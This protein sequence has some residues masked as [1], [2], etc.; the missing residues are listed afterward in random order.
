MKNSLLPRSFVFRAR[1]VLS[2]II[3]PAVFGLLLAHAQAG[4]TTWSGGG[5]SNV[6]GDANNWGGT[7]V[8]TNY[9]TVIFN[10][11]GAQ[12]TTSVINGNLSEN[13]LRWTGGSSWTLNNS[14]G[15][16]LSLYDNGGTQ[17]K[18]ENQSTGLV[19]INAP[20]IFAANN[21][22]PP[23]PFGEINAVNGD[24]TFASGTLTVNGSSVN[25]VKLFGSNHTTTFNNTVSS[26]G[27]WIGLT[28]ATTTMAVGGAF[29]SGD[30]YAMNGGTV[31]LNSGGTIT[32]SALRLGGDFG[33]TGNQNQ[34]LGGTFQFTNLTGGQ[35]FSGIINTVSGNTSNALLI[36]SL[37]TSGTNTLAGASFLDSDLKTQVASG[38]TLN[39]AGG[40][41]DVKTRKLT[42][43]GAGTTVINEALTSS[44]GAGGFLVK[45]GTGTL[46]LQGTANTYTGTSNAT[47]NAN[48]TQIA[49]GT[50]GIHGDGSLGLAPAGAYNNIQFT[51]SGTLQDTANNISLN[52]NR[53]V[54]ITSGATATFDSNGNTF[55]INGAIGGS[56]GNVGKTGGGSVVLN[57][58]NSYT[59][60]TAI[61][62]GTLQVNANNGLG[63]NAAGT[64]VSSGAALKLNS[65]NYSTVE[66]LQINGTGVS[67]GGALVNS[68]TS[69][70]AGQITA[71]TSSLISAGGGTLTLTGGI[72]KNGTTV[73][74]YGGPSGGAFNIN[75][76]GISGASANSDLVVDNASVALNVASTYNGPT[77]IRNA[78]TLNANV[79]NALPTLRSAMILDD[80]GSGS[81]TLA[82]GT[83]TN[84]VIASLTGAA[85]SV[86]ALTTSSSLTIGTGSGVTTFAGTIVG[87]PGTPIIKDSASTQ[88]LTGN[89][90]T[91]QGQI[92]VTAGVLE[93]NNTTGSASGTAGVS[94]TAGA[95]L[96]GTGR[97]E[98][99][100]SGGGVYINGDLVVGSTIGAPSVADFEI[101]T[102]AFT[103]GTTLDV[104]SRLTMELFTGA[105]LGDNS[106]LSTAAD[107]LK[108]VGKLDISN[109]ARL[110]V[111]NPN[112]MS[113]WAVGDRWR[114]FDWSSVGTITGSFASVDIALPTLS[115]G[116]V[117]DTSDLLTT[118]G[119]FSGTIDILAV[120]EPGSL[121]VGIFCGLSVAM[122][123]RRRQA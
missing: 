12:G 14:G 78:G 42:V 96:A 54:S 115:A 28:G 47:L 72:V 16:V 123:R 68:G 66:A 82:I 52:A 24:V 23:N 19:T 39:F 45:E 8:F 116:L 60:T 102:N 62:Q 59:G 5:G 20:I 41:V 79:S 121:L 35:S 88:I 17:A 111:A 53:N 91:Y 95:T 58:G 51:G 94:V 22:G 105:G 122:R 113:G 27:K 75:T 98:A 97:I 92:S 80:T 36:D 56:G 6:W 55:T 76:V 11:G 3:Q 44:F 118:S 117:W 2:T 100:A 4:D 25:G 7:N 65:V 87:G 109:G 38:G 77:Y 9:G 112:S 10:A 103:T 85:S 26:S 71:A 43:A 48:G 21:G 70:Y 13:G 49:G 104:N 15:S 64:T 74:L 63:T 86:L 18:I 81:S 50:L 33:A 67:G 69:T 32:T 110:V 119:A 114:I 99:S 34:T 40:S 61:S 84:N 107:R 1:R 108:I 120:P 101:A 46:I 89:S 83:G 31:K 73:T 106:A 93:A 57:V 90:S 29:T 30:I 37:N